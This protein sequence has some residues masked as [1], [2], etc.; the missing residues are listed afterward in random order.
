MSSTNYVKRKLLG[1]GAM[2]EVYASED[3]AT[4]ESV[5]V[6]NVR[7]TISMDKDMTARLTNEANLLERVVHHNVV[8]AIT[9]GEDADGAPYLVMSYVEGQTLWQLIEREGPL[10]L[11]RSFAIASQI[12]TGLAAIHE[13]RVVHADIKSNNV[14]VDDQDRVT[15]IDFGLAR[16]LSREIPRENML[17]GTPAFMAPETISGAAPSVAADIYAVGVI[18]Y[19]MLTGM[20]PF[21]HSSDI[22]DAHLH[23][24]VVVPSLR[25]PE[26]KISTDID[27]L[28]IRALSKD[29][30]DRFETARDFA[31]ALDAARSKDWRMTTVN[32][33]LLRGPATQDLGIRPTQEWARGSS[34]DHKSAAGFD[35]QKT[36]K[37]P[38]F[39][40][41]V[42]EPAAPAVAETN[43]S[44]APTASARVRDI[45]SL[46][47]DRA[48]RLL[49]THDFYGAISEL[50]TGLAQLMR[51]GNN[52]TLDHEAWRLEQ[53]LAALYDSL[54]RRAHARRMASLAYAHAR[55]TGNESAIERTKTLVERLDGR[56]SQV[57]P[58]TTG[59]KSA[60]AIG[61]KP[62]PRAARG[63]TRPAMK[64]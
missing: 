40:V 13:A 30:A 33:P 7:K 16:T 31:T 50:E 14:L 59:P 56:S 6:K 55:Q 3:P 64:R 37:L 51:L 63:S 32:M 19:E 45:I 54:G 26:A 38:T 15:I 48:S 28:V 2:G 29:A 61:P 25:N 62:G 11:E 60:P 41:T 24:P 47:L 21:A 23:E 39:S 17:A 53:V 44:N 42:N 5:A 49:E 52:I 34:T 8:R 18:L 58:Q 35:A 20:T 46:S 1:K 57:G 12:L 4:G 22:F 43:A 10:A 27:R 36:S 9:R